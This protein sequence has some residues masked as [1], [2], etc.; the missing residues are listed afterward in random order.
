M[1][2]CS[3]Q[4]HARIRWNLEQ[5]TDKVVLVASC[6]MNSPLSLHFNSEHE[7]VKHLNNQLGILQIDKIRQSPPRRMLVT[8]RCVEFFSMQLQSTEK[9]KKKDHFFERKIQISI[10]PKK[11]ASLYVMLSQ[12]VWKINEWQ[13]FHVRE[14][15]FQR[16]LG[17]WSCPAYQYDSIIKWLLQKC[18]NE[19]W[20]RAHCL[21]WRF[22]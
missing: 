13:H 7:H 10:F 15:F 12:C 3:F 9:S 18:P 17:K 14:Y 5:P 4:K 1:L 20:R 6:L 21:C 8:A 2:S 11:I 16:K 22:I 19:H